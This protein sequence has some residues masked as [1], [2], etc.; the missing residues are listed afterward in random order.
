MAHNAFKNR[1]CYRV[2]F[3]GGA[4]MRSSSSASKRTGGLI[5]VRTRPLGERQ[6]MRVLTQLACIAEESEAKDHSAS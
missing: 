2:C 5:R 3:D 1:V 6:A 4:L